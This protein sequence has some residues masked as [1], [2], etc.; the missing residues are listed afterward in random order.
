MSHV[1]FVGDI[2]Y[3]RKPEGGFIKERLDRAAANSE[4]TWHVVGC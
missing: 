3:L 4:C 2:F 1:G